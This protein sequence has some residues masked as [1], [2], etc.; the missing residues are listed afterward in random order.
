MLI[1]RRTR[2]GWD[3]EMFHSVEGRGSAVLGTTTR[4]LRLCPAFHP[5]VSGPDAPPRACFGRDGNDGL[6]KRRT[7]ADLREEWGQILQ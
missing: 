4:R 3:V 1:R 2:E 7:C 5:A 6:A